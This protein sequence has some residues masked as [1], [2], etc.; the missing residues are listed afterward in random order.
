MSD[1]NNK[2]NIYTASQAIGQAFTF[3]L[4]GIVSIHLETTSS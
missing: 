2:K 4:A 1:I 3:P